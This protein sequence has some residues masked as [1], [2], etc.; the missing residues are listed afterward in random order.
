MSKRLWLLGVGVLV[1]IA[2]LVACGTNYNSSSDGLLLVGSQGSGL[3][4]TFSFTVDKGKISAI[5]NS[6][7]DTA[8]QTCVLNG[9]PSSIVMDPTGA[10]A[11]T[12]INAIPQCTASKTGIATFKVNSSGTL[13][14]TGSLVSDANPVGMAMDP[15]GKFLFVAEGLGPHGIN[16]YAIGSGASLTPV[17]RT[18]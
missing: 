10:Y 4:E 17:A 9:V 2:V 3:I 14:A 1:S 11:Y 6:P 13:T 7:S 8:S 12:I 18:F 15:A 5:A 16:V